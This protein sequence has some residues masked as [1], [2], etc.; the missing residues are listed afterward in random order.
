MKLISCKIFDFGKLHNKEIV[1]TDGLNTINEPNG[2]GKSTLTAFIKAMLYGLEGDGKRDDL[3]S[4]RRHYKPWQGGT[5]GGSMDFEVKGKQYRVTRTFGPKAGT[6]TFELRDASTLLISDD[7][8]EKLGEELF[9]ISSES[10][11]RTVFIKQNNS[12]YYR[13]TDDINAKL[14]NIS[15]SMDINLFA[16]IDEHIKDRLNAL[17]ASRK[18]GEIYKL[19]ETAT[20]LKAKIREC[21]GAGPGAQTVRG[22]LEASKDE[23]LTLT[24]EKQSLSES[25]RKASLFA[26]KKADRETWESLKQDLRVKEEAYDT[27]RKNLGYFG[28]GESGDAI[29]S[30]MD[31][32]SQLSENNKIMASFSMSEAELKDLKAYSERI[33]DPDLTLDRADEAINDLYTAGSYSRALSEKESALSDL[34]F[35]NEEMTG[36]KKGLNFQL[37]I[38]LLFLLLAAAFVFFKE[39]FAYAYF[40]T[41]GMTCLFLILLITYFVKRK[42]LVRD[43]EVRSHRIEKLR[44]DYDEMNGFVSEAYSKAESILKDNG[45]LFDPSTAVADLKRLYQDCREFRG[46]SE[47][48]A[49]FK[50]NDKTDVC[51]ELAVLISGYFKDFGLDPSES[52]YNAVLSSL[53]RK[54]EAVNTQKEL[55][56]DSLNR[57]QEFEKNNDTEALS[58]ENDESVISLDEINIREREIDERLEVL[59]KGSELDRRQL[60][61]LNERLDEAADLSDRLES[62]EELIS[63]KSDTSKLLEET[64]AYLNKAKESLTARYIGPLRASFS[65]YYSLITGN[66]ASGFMLDAN[67]DLTVEGGGLQHAIGYLSYGYKDLVGVCMRLS[68][69]DA[70]YPDEKPVLILDDPFVNLDEHNRVGAMKLLESVSKEYQIVHF[71]CRE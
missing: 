48:Y 63:G 51:N 33:Q 19:K 8:S 18:T 24:K 16:A 37:V 38:D 30:I 9:N 2:W 64:R 6:D 20:E 68:L 50:Q 12:E 59:R 42:N 54:N 40:A 71:S 61:S 13:A 69:A 58:K 66:D 35:E 52:E 28:A 29:A 49:K 10:F 47:K 27:A 44:S 32:T 53:I 11:S 62:I 67:L 56:S 3:V 36:K 55:Y 60:D 7:Y 41:A 25:R 34:E 21:E 17:S 45:V 46:L 4:D 43:I 26:K 1:F 65:K 70:M 14:G 57:L 5:F 31:L 39:H 22:R 23:I 15:D